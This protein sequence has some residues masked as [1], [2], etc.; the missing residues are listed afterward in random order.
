VPKPLAVVPEL[1][2]ELDDLYALPPEDFTQAR[3]DLAQR[4]KQAGQVEDAASVKQLRKP[5]VALWAVNQLARRDGDEI[6]ALLEAVSRLRAAQQAALLGESEEL[7]AATAEERRL[8]RSLTQQGELLLQQAGH[9]ADPK[10]IAGTLRAASVDPSGRELLEQGRLSEE[11][12]ATGFG[13]FTGM[14]IP[15]ESKPKKKTPK[16]PSPAVRRRQEER[17]R[18][19]RERVTKAKHDA[20]KAE[21]DTARAETAL[22]EARRKAAH[23]TDSLRRAEAELEDAETG[24]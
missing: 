3:N 9:S 18:K 20:T 10:R 14:E 2:A 16:A 4:L 1:E 21:R 7:R 13:A 23:A 22:E 15:V 19:L 12:E 5:T 11:L 8:V 17:L 6:R 24:E